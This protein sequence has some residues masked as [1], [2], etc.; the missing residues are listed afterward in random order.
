MPTEVRSE[1]KIPAGYRSPEA[2]SFVAQLDDQL[3]RLLDATRELTA[4]DLMWQPAP[5]MNTIGMLLAH[6][7][8]V[9]VWWTKI[10]LGKEDDPDVRDVIGIGTDDDGMPL[11]EGAPAFPLL[12]GNEIAFYHDLLA[13]ARAFVTRAAQAASPDALDQTLTRTRPD[14]T[15]RV[16]NGRWYFYHVLEHFAGH[17][18]QIL[19]LK[20][21]RRAAFVRS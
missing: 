18:G 2:A 12:N 14:G 4:D 15:K 16:I 11:A 6:L 7:A 8:V 20:H 5:G 1:I 21:M 9:E 19:L 17:Y 10:V 13:K 3:A